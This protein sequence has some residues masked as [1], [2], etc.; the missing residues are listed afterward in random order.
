MSLKINV[1]TEAAN[2]AISIAEFLAGRSSLNTSDK[3]LSATTQV[4]RLLADMPGLGSSRDYGQS[5]SGLRVWHVPNFPKYLIFYRATDTELTI[6]RVLH[7][8]QNIT[9]I[10]SDPEED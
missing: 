1:T 10:F 4:Y 2:D 7:G 8:A 6:L 9:Q 5:F 3:F